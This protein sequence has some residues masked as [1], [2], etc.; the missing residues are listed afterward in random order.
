MR[1]KSLKAR[2]I[3]NSR[4]EDTI[5]VIINKKYKASAPSG[6][7][8]G[9]HEVI[10]FKKNVE[11]AVNYLNKYSEI[12]KI[13]F[14]EFED[15][16]K[17]EN[18]LKILGGNPV[19][20]LEFALLKAMSDGE[21]WRFLL[22]GRKKMPTPLGNCV[23]GGKHIKGNA[24][25]IQ[26]FLIAAKEKKF[27]KAAAINDYL[28]QKIGTVLK[29]KKK[30]DEGA[31]APNISNL[32]VFELLNKTI[33][34]VKKETGRK[35]LLGVDVAATSFFKNGYYFYK[36]FSSAERFKKL[37]RKQQI[38]F[39]KETIKKYKLFYVE[40]PLYEEDFKGF[41]F[42][43]KR[44]CLVCGDDLICTNIKL[45]KKAIKN[46]SVNAIIV[47]PNQVGSL[48]K[49]KEIIEFARKKEIKTIISHRSGE[50]LDAT[51]A[52]LAVGFRVPYIKCGIFGKERRAKINELI[53]I[54][55][56]F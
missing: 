36:N 14:E 2:K 34:E 3:K 47:K 18:L 54:E 9:K 48:I 25:D 10:A 4:G 51:I 44:K 23:G 1:V 43:E 45:L 37:N 16:A 31:W 13:D 49:T 26:E 8:K 39:I 29:V 50:T 12:K 33:E 7:S 24:P 6:A 22:K 15:L 27:Y 55:R 35:I 19:I 11:Y 42:F 30:T 46:N 38:N 52:H 56:E 40:D 32:E 53:R 20:A 28:Y 21:V 5:E 17:V 41:S